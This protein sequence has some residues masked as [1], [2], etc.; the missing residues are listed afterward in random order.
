MA[1]TSGTVSAASAIIKNRMGEFSPKV[2]IILGSGLGPFADTIENPVIIS[3]GDLPGFPHAGVAGHAGQIVIGR[4]GATDVAVMQGRAHYY[5]TGSADA[6]AVPVQTLKAIGC[7][8]LLLTNAAGSTNPDAEPGSIMLLSDHISFTGVSPLFGVQG[9]DRFVDLSD[10]YD[11]DI[12]KTFETVAQDANVPL[13]NGIYW[14][15]C[16]PHF[17]TPAEIRAITLLG[18]TAVGMSTVPEVIL[19]RHAGLKVGALSIITNLAAGM[20]PTKLSHEQTQ[21]NAK[22][23]TENVQKLLQGFLSSYKG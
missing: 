7:E 16:G 14:W 15:H 8:T 10:A 5:E 4:V 6:M 23:A 20:S 1:N 11:P 2:G 18:A 13:F 9:D 3:Y 17:E 21:T 12:R 19:A 22:L